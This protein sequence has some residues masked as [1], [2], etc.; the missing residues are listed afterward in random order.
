MK[1]LSSAFE[2]SVHEDKDELPEAITSNASAPV[3]STVSNTGTLVN[4]TS[5]VLPVTVTLVNFAWELVNNKSWS[6]FRSLSSRSAT[7]AE[8]NAGSLSL[9]CVMF[10]VSRSVA[11]DT[12]ADTILLPVKTC[13]TSI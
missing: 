11:P 3:K 10:T 7:S 5:P 8:A 13:N 12:S 2:A 4:L 1:V 6:A 9:I